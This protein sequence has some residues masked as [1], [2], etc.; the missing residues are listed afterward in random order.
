MSI[1]IV[2]PVIIRI[3]ISPWRAAT[4][5]ATGH[6]ITVTPRINAHNTRRRTV[7]PLQ[8]LLVPAHRQYQ[9][10]RFLAVVYA[11]AR[12]LRRYLLLPSMHQP[13]RDPLTPDKV[14]IGVFPSV[15]PGRRY[16]FD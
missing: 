14:M 11:V 4:R 3:G 7:D 2:I 12:I 16:P 6:P 10:L 5:R 1:G 13:G 8:G 15:P 9:Q